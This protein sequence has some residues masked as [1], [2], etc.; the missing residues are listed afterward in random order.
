MMLKTMKGATT[1][2]ASVLARNKASDI[3]PNAAI[4]S[5]T[6]ATANGI[7][8]PVQCAEPGLAREEQITTLELQ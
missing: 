2:A 8:G 7:E 6:P 1:I 5:T 3:G 4:I